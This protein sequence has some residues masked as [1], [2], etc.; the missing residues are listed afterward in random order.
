MPVYIPVYKDNYLYAKC[1]ELYT[2][3]YGVLGMSVQDL[4]YLRLLTTLL[5]CSSQTFTKTLSLVADVNET[6]ASDINIKLI[7]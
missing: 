6:M 5:G 7:N 3:K 2:S 1:A 4:Q